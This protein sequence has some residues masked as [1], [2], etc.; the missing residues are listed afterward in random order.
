VHRAPAHLHPGLWE[1]V[2]WAVKHK[3]LN[4]IKENCSFF[5]EQFESVRSPDTLDPTYG[6]LL[7]QISSQH[8]R[9]AIAILLSDAK[10][11][12]F[13][14]H[15]RLSGAL[16]V[17]LLEMARADPGQV[18]QWARQGLIGPFLDAWTA[19]A[20]DV[21]S[22]IAALS[23]LPYQ[24]DYEYREDY[25]YARWWYN[26][27]SAQW[28]LGE[29]ARERMRELAEVTDDDGDPRVRVCS[30]LAEGDAGAFDQAMIDLCRQHID[31]FKE[32]SADPAEN[33]TEGQVFVEGLALVRLAQRVG[34]PTSPEYPRVPGL[35]RLVR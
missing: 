12:T 4:I 27:A 6:E 13:R 11:D 30:A 21:A 25:Q 10:L 5:I 16:R 23:G 32:R 29:D 2:A 9:L 19:G 18:A 24:P 26:V 22:R 7:A 15:L 31:W 35:A 34:L 14:E 33:D 17:K 3:D 28:Q 20:D 1:R 8:R